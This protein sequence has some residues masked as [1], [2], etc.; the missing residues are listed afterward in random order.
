MAKFKPGQVANP[1]GRHGKAGKNI[2]P[3]SKMMAKFCKKNS[4]KLG[5]LA[6]DMLEDALKG[7][8]FCRKEIG[9]YCFPTPGTFVSITKE[10]TKEV[11]V[12]IQHARE[13]LT[14]EEEQT[15]WNLLQK[16]KKGI[17]AFGVSE[18]KEE[19]ETIEGVIEP[20]SKAD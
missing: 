13:N 10:D 18:N 2:D 7:D 16:R 9:K 4:R 11:N 14:H 15:L 5:Q 20:E 1:Y 3:R 12:L 19:P 6:Q 8:R 17:P